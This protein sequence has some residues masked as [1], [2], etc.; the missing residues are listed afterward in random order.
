MIMKEIVK[1]KTILMRRPIDPKK[2]WHQAKIS[3]NWGILP[4]FNVPVLGS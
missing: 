1:K 4:K 3:G 2:N